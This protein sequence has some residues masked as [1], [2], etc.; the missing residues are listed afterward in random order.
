[1]QTL[2]TAVV[3]VFVV[4]GL[5][6]GAGRLC[7]LGPRGTEVLNRFVY[8]FALPALLIRAIGEAPLGEILNWGFIAAFAIGIVVTWAVTVFIALKLKR[9][10]PAVAVMRAVNTTYGNTGYLGIPLAA[11]AFGEAAV[12][13]AS[14]SLVINSALILTVATALLEVARS[15]ASMGRSRPLLGTLR[16]LAG[17]PRI[18]SVAGGLLLA[19]FRVSQPRPIDGIVGMLGDAAGP[20]ALFAIGLFVAGRPLT[21]GLGQLGITVVLKLALLPAVVWLL[22][23]YVF[24]L[25]PMWAAVA[26]LMAGVPVGANAFILAERYR[27]LLPETST[28]IVVTTALSLLTLSL[29]LLLLA[30]A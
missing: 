26:V 22:V 12:V 19:G 25:E 6:Y 17:N 9:E 8:V 2:L 7:V 27:T 23:S 4:I 1:M 20:C 24:A 3:P 5:G 13:P 30:G 29:M 16:A 14:L 10:A 21:Q 15:R 18:W 28:A 11:T